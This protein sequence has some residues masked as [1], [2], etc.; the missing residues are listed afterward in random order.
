MFLLKSVLRTTVRSPARLKSSRA[1]FN[2]H[3]KINLFSTHITS[4][5][6]IGG[7]IW[8]RSQYCIIK[9]NISDLRRTDVKVL[10]GLAS[11]SYCT[12]NDSS[13]D[14]IGLDGSE[15]NQPPVLPATVSIPDVWPNLPVIATQRN[16]VF[17]RF[18]K[19]LEVSNPLL[20]DL[21]RRKVK[22][23]QPYVGIFLKKSDSDDN[24]VVNKLDEIYSVGTFAQVQEMQDL[25]DKLRLVVIAHRRIKINGQLFED[26]EPPQVKGKLKT[27]PNN[28]VCILN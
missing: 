24:E 7:D 13:D 23:N 5:N 19:I 12:K 2:G 22:L 10:S 3:E 27:S 4:Q 16:P 15:F 26:L 14:E 1:V 20:I 9:K 17:P 28:F 11:R 25:G 18:M 21:I 6:T 8:S